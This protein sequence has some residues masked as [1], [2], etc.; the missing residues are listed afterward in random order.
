M[1]TITSLTLTWKVATVK[2]DDYRVMLLDSKGKAITDLG[3]ISIGEIIT[4]KTTGTM[5]VMITGCEL[6]KKYSFG[7]IAFT[8][9]PSN[10]EYAESTLAKVKVTVPKYTAVQ[11]L[12]VDKT[13]VGTT[14]GVTDSSVALEWQA[15]KANT[16]DLA[17][18]YIVLW[19][20]GKQEKAL[21]E[22]PGVTADINPSTL[23][24]TI[25]GLAADKKYTFAVKE[26]ALDGE[27]NEI[28]TSLIAKVSAKTLKPLV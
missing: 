2:T 11:K 6:G 7:V 13:A 4:G 12:K 26:I 28:A 5:Q 17:V 1:T 18:K 21:S 23:K 8:D 25:T 3:S 20:D 22:L 9:T 24:A 16:G 15:S 14:K 10:R 27:G 19:M